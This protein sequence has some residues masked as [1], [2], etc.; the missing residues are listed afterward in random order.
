MKGWNDLP[1]ELRI[2]DPKVRHSRSESPRKWE[3]LSLK[4]DF[5]RQAK[6]IA[7]GFDDVAN[8]W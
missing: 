4:P 3:M 8:L 7:M 1:E 5:L 6:G 2:P